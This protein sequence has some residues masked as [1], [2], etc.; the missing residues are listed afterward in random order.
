MS[1]IS[2][3]RAGKQRRMELFTPT[4]LRSV[5][6]RPEPERKRRR[7]CGEPIVSI[8]WIEE[9]RVGNQRV[10]VEPHVAPCS[11]RFVW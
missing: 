9:E 7:V 3:L 8:P 4:E 1:T 10:V 2:Y 11:E 5:V 6:E